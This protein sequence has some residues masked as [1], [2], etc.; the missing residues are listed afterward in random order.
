MLIG[1]NIR[2]LKA[3]CVPD[4]IMRLVIPGTVTTVRCFS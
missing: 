2:T 1:N 4:I 3:V